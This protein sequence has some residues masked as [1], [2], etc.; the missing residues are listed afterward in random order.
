MTTRLYNFNGKNVSDPSIN[1]KFLE[2]LKAKCPMNGDANL[3]IPLD[4]VSSQ[5]FDGRIFRNIRAGFAVIASDARLYDDNIT[6]RI[7]DS[8]LGGSSF[9]QDFP[10]AMVKMGQIGVKTGLM[11]EIRRKCNSFN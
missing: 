7:V 8:Y 3:R 10:K 9:L 1:P 5:T 4:N 11:G 2:E 6:K